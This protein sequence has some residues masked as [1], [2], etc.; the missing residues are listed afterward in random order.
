MRW[1]IAIVMALTA[2]P[3]LAAT[4]VPATDPATIE[5]WADDNLGAA[6]SAGNASAATIV[7]V[8]GGRIVLTR[9][10]GDGDRTAKTPIAPP[11]NRFLIASVT[12]T[13]TATAVALLVAD[14]RIASLDDPVNKYLKRMQLPPAFG[15]QVTIRQLLTHSAGFEERGFGIGS[16]ADVTIPA[17]GDYVRARLPA[18]VRPP[19]SRIVYANIDPALLGVLIEDITG[20]T[21]REVVANRILAPL[22][23]RDSE[24][25]YDPAA[26]DRLVRPYRGTTAMPFEINSPFYAPTGSIHTTA[27]DMARYLN[28][29]LGHAADILPPS[30]TGML[31]RPL[32]QNAPGL[33]PLG[34]A[35][36]LTRW[37][38]H[39]I[40][41]HAGGFSGFS[42]D[43][44]FVPDSD[45][46]VF[47]SWA[48]EPAPG[49]AKPLDYGTLQG[50]MLSLL[51]GPYQPP[52]PL[53]VQPDPSAFVGRY[54]QERRPQTNFE[55]IMAADAVDTVTRAEQ[56]ALT[57][58]GKGPYYAVAPRIYTSAAEGGRPSP[59]YVFA[60]DVALSRVGA[61]TRV[62][63][64]GDPATH[65]LI[66]QVAL[67]VLASGLLGLIWMRGRARLLAPLVALGA[68]ALPI[69]LL[70]LPPGLEA[71]II[72]GDAA[73]FIAVKLLAILVVLLA[74]W[75]AWLATRVGQRRIAGVHGVA[76]GLAAIALLVPLRFFH[77]I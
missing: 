69:M 3:A 6:V 50:S 4:A 49:Q 51:L 72:G 53:A 48:G 22:G 64:F 42:A 60:D 11:R 21:M 17:T 74:C 59:V 67:G 47:Y 33:D 26:A 36:F 63:G 10:Y 54:W 16:H 38:G 43:M 52:A 41:G 62:S 20:Q 65:Q 39:R 76:M 5:R 24:L 57:I 14:G 18:I 15:R 68:L 2:M 40:V 13:F 19:G 9:N 66:M 58:N 55:A 44:Y 70:F 45:L 77:L 31:H 71:A 61:A 27:T 73:R 46:G 25:V 1:L 30:V 34:M 23:M 56:N 7:V 29:Q 35:F 75:L 12:K 28:A 8:K 37:N 32:A